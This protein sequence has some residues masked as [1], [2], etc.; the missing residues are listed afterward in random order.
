MVRS[1]RAIATFMD[2]AD[3]PIGLRHLAAHHRWAGQPAQVSLGEISERHV[4]PD[5][6]RLRFLAYN[7]FL[8]RVRLALAKGLAD[9]STPREVMEALQVDPRKL[10]DHFDVCDLLPSGPV[11]VPGPRELCHAAGDAV[12]FVIDQM[13][14]VDAAVNAVISAMGTEKAI[15]IALGIAGVPETIELQAKPALAARAREIGDTLRNDGYDL[16]A[17]CEVW[18]AEYRADLL[19]HWQLPA[20]D[21]HMGLGKPEGDAFLGDGLLVGSPG[22]RIIELRRHSYQARGIDRWPG[23]V[24]DMVADDELWAGKG[25]LLAR[26]DVGVGIVDLYLTHLYFGTGLAGT[27]V[28][29]YFPHVVPPSNQE[30]R[31]VRQ[32][33]LQELSAFITA[34]HRPEHVAVVCGDFNIDAS[35]RDPEYGGHDALSDFIAHHN[36]EDRWISPH[37][38]LMGSTGGDFEQIC[39]LP[40]SGDLR[41]CDDPAV[42]DD[43]GG[44]RIDFV[45]IERAA[46]QHVFDLDCTRVRRRPFPRPQA[47]GGQAHM[48]DHLG[49]DCTWLAS[50]RSTVG[51]RAAPRTPP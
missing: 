15:E 45:L 22:G 18:N 19:A 12:D 32:A 11:F 35:G 38:G 6:V 37:A 9:M 1:L 42:S 27:D 49:L 46:P 23:Q 33:Q 14:G 26:V 43:S 39:P 41:F 10:L 50:R 48:S 44:Y 7:T 4:R 25:V 13:G 16:A 51:T 5:S 34:T 21:T 47:T 20:S 17:L 30:R 3:D 2:P 31:D 28:S 8:M 36:L 40:Q 29:Q 24:L